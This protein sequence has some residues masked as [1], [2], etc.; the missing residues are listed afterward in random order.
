MYSE[1]ACG[2]R[3]GDQFCVYVGDRYVVRMLTEEERVAI[4]A[5]QLSM[6]EKIRDYVR[7]HLAFRYVE[8][9]DY[10]TAMRVENA[11]K[12]GALGTGPHLNP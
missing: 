3:S 11:V 4:G 9:G 12:G 2:R 5:A 8:V 7:A 1:T 10:A 6:D